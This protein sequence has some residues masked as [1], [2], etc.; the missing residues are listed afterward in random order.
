MSFI[1]KTVKTL[2]HEA[3]RA[4]E[5]EETAKADGLLQQIDPRVKVIGLL[6]LILDVATAR[7][8]IF[9]FALFA[10]AVSLAVSSRISL[11]ALATHV[12][13]AVLLFTGLIALPAIFITPGEPLYRLFSSLTITVQGLR[14]AVF[15]IM[16]TETACQCADQPVRLGPTC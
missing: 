2:A 14:S 10:I 9:L 16:R 11:R 6:L 13:M 4:L 5:A 1:E 15:L 8:L 7:H 12:W 3:E